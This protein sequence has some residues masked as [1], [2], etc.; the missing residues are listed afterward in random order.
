MIDVNNVCDYAK[1]MRFWV[2]RE[3]DSEY[4][5]YGAYDDVTK[6]FKCAKDIDNALLIENE[7]I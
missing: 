7:L 5:F 4:W 6:A 3:V 2:V 1:S